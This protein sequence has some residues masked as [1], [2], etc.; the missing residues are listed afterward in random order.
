[1]AVHLK[2]AHYADIIH[3]L[4]EKLVAPLLDKFPYLPRA[5]QLSGYRLTGWDCYAQ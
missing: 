1:M 5:E 3:V 4:R 2:F